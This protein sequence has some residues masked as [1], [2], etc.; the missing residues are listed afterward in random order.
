LYVYSA[1][2]NAQNRGAWYSVNIGEGFMAIVGATLTTQPSMVDVAG[3]PT[4]PANFRFAYNQE[5]Q[6]G[7]PYSVV[8]RADLSY[9]RALFF[10]VSNLQLTVFPQSA[11]GGREAQALYWT[12]ANCEYYNLMDR[13]V[14]GVG[15][16]VQLSRT[17][18]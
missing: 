5:L 2:F 10:G 17:C 12:R 1:D 7:S 4:T 11:W 13:F 14:Q 6:W 8:F 9:E 15:H 18:W 16:R 3:S